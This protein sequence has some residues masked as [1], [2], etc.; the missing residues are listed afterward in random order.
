MADVTKIDLDEIKRK[1]D[2]PPSRKLRKCLQ[3]LREPFSENNDRAARSGKKIGRTTQAHRWERVKLSI[4][5]LHAIGYEIEDGASFKHK[6]VFALMRYWIARG[7]NAATIQNRLSAIRC[8]LEWVNKPGMLQ[9]AEHYLPA[10]VD[11]E[12]VRIVSV[13]Q[14]PKGWAENGVNLVEMIEKVLQIDSRVAVV[15]LLSAAFGVRRREAC[16]F[17]P[18]VE[19]ARLGGELRIGQMISI[20]EGTKGGRAR[21]VTVNQQYQIDI[22]NLALSFCRRP[23]SSMVP[24][25]MDL[26]QF[27]NRVRNVCSRAGMTKANNC[28]P[29]AMRHTYAV[30]LYE[31]ISGFQ[32]PV[33]GNG[34]FTPVEEGMNQVGDMIDTAARAVAKNLGHE[35]PQITRAYVGGLITANKQ[36]P[37]GEG[38]GASDTNQS[39]I[40]TDGADDSEENDN[41]GEN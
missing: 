26:Q 35:R 1:M 25:G 10:G 22:I 39:D 41:H 33:R 34:C 30:N 37:V 29:H 36:I 5:E 11:P 15:I 12:R 9:S 40:C 38:D 31:K 32:A 19:L 18:G 7:F 24:D 6:H 27:L 17:R 20:K 14:K 23:N 3:T 8:Y 21:N 13:A 16:C 4:R 28:H 2:E